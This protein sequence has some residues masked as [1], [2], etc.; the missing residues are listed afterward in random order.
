MQRGSRSHDDQQQS[1]GGVG[2]GGGGNGGGGGDTKEEKEE[3]STYTFK[4]RRQLNEAKA[5]ALSGAC[6]IQLV[7]HTTTGCIISGNSLIGTFNIE[8]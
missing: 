4:E 7:L 5:V 8:L 3:R 6:G 2:G 1:F